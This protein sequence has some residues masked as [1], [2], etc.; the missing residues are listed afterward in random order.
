MGH[1]DRVS[2]VHIRNESRQELTFTGAKLARSV[3]DAPKC[4]RNH[5]IE[6]S[7]AQGVPDFRGRRR[8]GTY[9]CITI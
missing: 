9:C 4:P 8:M 5:R 6:G 2:D 1:F 7:S 3:A